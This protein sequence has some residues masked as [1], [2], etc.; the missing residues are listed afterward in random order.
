MHDQITKAVN[1][2]PICQRNKKQRKKF[3]HLLPKEAKATPWDELCVDLIGPYSIR[4]KG[5]ST[6]K[7][8]CVN[9]IDP[10]IGWLEVHELNDKRSG[11]VANTV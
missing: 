4:R 11:T 2:C 7:C 5:Q 8:Q 10:A 6:I 3:G 1:I 9:M